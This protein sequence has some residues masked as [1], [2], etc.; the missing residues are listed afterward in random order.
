[1]RDCCRQSQAEVVSKSSNKIHATWGPPFSRA[2]YIK[3]Q[4]ATVTYDRPAS[5]QGGVSPLDWHSFRSR[6]S[7]SFPRKCH[8]ISL[9]QRHH[10][11]LPLT[12]MCI[13][14]ERR[15]CESRLLYHATFYRSKAKFHHTRR[16]SNIVVIVAANMQ[17]GAAGHHPRGS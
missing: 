9:S 8:L 5:E 14:S 12:L 17:K 16:R 10:R 6:I 13:L 11:S 15:L 2:L 7:G 4:R 1:M 3:A